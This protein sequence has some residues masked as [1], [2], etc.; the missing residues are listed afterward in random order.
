MCECACFFLTSFFF[1][2]GDYNSL[3]QFHADALKKEKV[4]GTFLKTSMSKKKNLFRKKGPEAS[5]H[6][7]VRP[8]H[9][10][11]LEMFHANK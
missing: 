5:W 11:Q 1:L 7:F 4:A 6:F 2:L 3:L 8:N 10:S 9:A